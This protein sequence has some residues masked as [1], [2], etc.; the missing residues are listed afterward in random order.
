MPY[1]N[2]RNDCCCDDSE[3]SGGQG[4]Q[5]A[6]GPQGDTGATGAQGAQGTQGDTGATGAQGAQGAQGDT[7]ATGAQGAQGAQGSQGAG[8][9]GAQG[10]QGAQG[11]TGVFGEFTPNGTI[12]FWSDL[13]DVYGRGSALMNFIDVDLGPATLRGFP[14]LP[15]GMGAFYNVFGAGINVPSSGS[16]FTYGEYMPYNG[17]IVG[18]AINLYSTSLISMKIYAACYGG[19]GSP[20]A[21]ELIGSVGGID[22]GSIF[23]NTTGIV[24]RETVTGRISFNPGVPAP[25]PFGRGSYIG[26]YVSSGGTAP[27]DIAIEGTL[28]VRLKP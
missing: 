3:S 24:G 25:V 13:G 23:Y 15:H 27:L 8:G 14:I 6:Q 17:E 1:K 2:F 11:A 28:Y 18:A 10:A 4:A 21:Q 26:I 7:G 9:A 12:S 16:G 22:E 19:G 20:F 5:G